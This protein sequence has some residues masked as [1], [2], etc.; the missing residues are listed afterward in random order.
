MQDKGGNEN[1]VMFLSGMGGTGK[2]EVIKAFVYFAKNISYVFGWNY[3]TDVIKITALTGSAACQI[4]NGKTLHSQACLSPRQR[5]SQENVKSWASTKVLVIDEVSFLNETTLEKLDKNMRTLKQSS[6]LLYGGI[7]VIFVGDFF[8]MLPCTGNPL[9]KNNT[10]QFGA[11]NKAVFLNVSHR[12]KQDPMYGEIM[13]RHRAGKITTKDIH[14][15]NQRFI[16]NQNV[17]LPTITKVRCACYRNDERNAYNNVIFL[18]HLEITNKKTKDDTIICPDHTCIIKARMANTSNKSGFLNKSMYN[19]LLDECGDSDITNGNETFVDPALKF[20]HNIPLMMNTNERIDEKLANGTP[21]RGLYITLKEGCHFQPEC[22]EGYMVNT[23]YADEVKHLV[24]IPE[25]N[26]GKYFL[27][28]PETRQCKIKL[29]MLNNMVLKKIKITYIPINCN[30]STTGHKLQGATL[31]SLVVNSWAY[32]CPHWV[33]VV[34]SR[35]RELKNLVLN[36]K[37][38]VHRNYEARKDLVRWEQDMKKSIETKTFKD[39]GQSD[40]N[41]YLEE[42]EKYLIK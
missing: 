19:R 26:S 8:Q 10:V 13:R 22:W 12:F 14:T 6:D 16:E 27:V 9:F 36:E 30:I 31:N 23:V 42:E 11:I 41:Q 2:S 24:C 7:L 35:V 21:C 20:F 38:D 17:N 39:R 25:D 40:Y 15:I 5:I 34:L 4:P 18:K 33:Y 29:R 32:G 3:D 37:L 1:L 28:K